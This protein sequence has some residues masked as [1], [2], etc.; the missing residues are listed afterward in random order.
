MKPK[1]EQKNWTAD[2]ET[3]RNLAVIQ[4]HLGEMNQSA[5]I[6]YCIRQTFQQM[7]AQRPQQEAG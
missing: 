7:E 6:R 1:F 5:T 2:P 4:S 3:L